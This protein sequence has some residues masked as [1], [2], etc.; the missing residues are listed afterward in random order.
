MCGA[1]PAVEHASLIGASKES[2]PVNSTVRYQCD[3]GYGQRHLPFIRCMPSGQWEEPQVECTE[4]EQTQFWF[5]PTPFFTILPYKTASYHTVRSVRGSL[6]NTNS[7]KQQLFNSLDF[8]MIYFVI[9]KM[10]KES[11]MA[12]VSAK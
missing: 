3:A 5:I 1:P 2:Y 12:N 11:N 6:K 4:G 7:D 10:N 8:I 9:L